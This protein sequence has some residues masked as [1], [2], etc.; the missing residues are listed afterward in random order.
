M[1]LWAPSARGSY[2]KFL[3]FDRRLFDATSMYIFIKT[4]TGK[5]VTLEVNQADSIENV[6]RKIQSKEG[7]SLERQRLSFAGKQ[8]LDGETLS[9]CNIQNKAILHLTVRPPWFFAVF[10]RD[11]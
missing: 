1:D 3:F 11:Q 6:K 2:K 8:L 9:D 7:I 10:C 4:S 5:T